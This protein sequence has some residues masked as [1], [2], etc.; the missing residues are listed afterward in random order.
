MSEQS[1]QHEFR[2]TSIQTF[3]DELASSAPTPGGGAATALVGAMGAALVSMVCNLTI[4]RPRYANVEAA[5]RQILAR[6][7]QIRQNLVALAE[8]DAA[9]YADV[10]AAYRLPR[11]SEAEKAARADAIQHALVRAVGPPLAVMKECR[12]LVPL[13]L[14]VAAHGNVAVVS[15]AGVAAELAAAGVHASILNVR[16]NLAEIRDAAFVA[17]T[18]TEIATVESGLEDELDRAIGIVRAK[19]APK[20]AS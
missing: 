14:Q 7:E 19:L 2:S 15:D 13:C 11:A 12:T 10:A 20:A 6:S 3:L 1:I 16:V 5:M 18:E 4:G 17:Q 9:A 8:E